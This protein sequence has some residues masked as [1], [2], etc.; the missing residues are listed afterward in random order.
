MTAFE[1]KVKAAIDNLPDQGE[2]AE[3]VY[4]FEPAEQFGID[5]SG[6]WAWREDDY[7]GEEKGSEYWVIVGFSE[8]EDKSNP[9]YAKFDYYYASYNGAD[10]ERWEFVKPVEKTILVFE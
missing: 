6:V 4:A 7:G 1:K 3:E 9:I 2:F 5:L 10:Y 8:S